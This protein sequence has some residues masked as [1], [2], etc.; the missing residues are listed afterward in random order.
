VDAS[1]LELAHDVGSAGG[2]ATLEV[3]VPG[4]SGPVRTSAARALGIGTVAI[5]VGIVVFLVA[6]GG[7][8]GTNGWVRVIL[9]ALGVVAI[10]RGSDR[11]LKWR[12][13]PN[14]DTAFWVSVGWLGALILAAIL[15]NVLPLGEHVDTTKTLTLVG[16]QQPDLFS[17]HPLGT[18]N[19]ALDILGRCIY[20]ARVSLL[21]AAFA[22]TVS[23]IV[24]GAIGLL[25]GYHRGWLD[26]GVGLVTDT[27]LAFPALVLLLA[28]ATVFGKPTHVPEAVLKS[29]ISLAIVGLPTMVRLARANTLTFAQREFVLSA[30][31]MGAGS[32]RIVFRE[33]LPNV[34]LTLVSFGLV[35]MA[36]LIVAEGSLSFLGLGL[37][38]PQPSWGNMIAEGT[39]SNVLR[40]QPWVPLIPGV[41]MFITLL[42]F[43]RVGE[44]ARRA[45]DPRDLKV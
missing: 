41:F 28:L 27:V 31:S 29:G 8:S 12:K 9:A 25:A 35:L 42:C 16:N 7:M 18:N 38:P 5:A 33:L 23:I 30:R 24:G 26:T 4:A 2:V 20:G 44:K 21:T 6:A 17:A 10:Y 40:G 1:E 34:L 45:W 43:N 36:V 14:F 15:A 11:I 22:V 37:Q 19:L 13:G 3:P 39:D 32:T